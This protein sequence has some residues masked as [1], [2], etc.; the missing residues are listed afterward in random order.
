MNRKST[1]ILTLGIIQAVFI[2]LAAFTQSSEAIKY[3]DPDSLNTDGQQKIE[4]FKILDTKCNV[5]HRKQNP[6]MVF[7]LKNMVRRAPRIYNA[8]FLEQRM[9]KGDKIRLTNDESSR[10]KSWL[11][12]QELN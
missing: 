6:F 8:V 11:L 2:L 12:T 9:P 4:V 1:K 7:N 5:C 3:A 10:L